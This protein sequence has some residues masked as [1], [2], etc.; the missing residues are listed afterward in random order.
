MNKYIIT[1]NSKNFKLT[2]YEFEK[3]DSEFKFIKWIDEG[4]GLIET[5]LNNTELCRYI[6]TKPVIF[7]RH[8]FRVDGINYLNDFVDAIV[9]KCKEC[10]EVNSSFTVQTRY[11]KGTQVITDSMS[12]E[13]ANILTHVGY[14]VDVTKGENIISILIDGENV[15]W[16][17]GNEKNN[18]SH[19]RGGMPHYSST[20]KYRF[21]SR[22]EYKLLEA[23]ECFEIDIKD[24]KKAADLGAAPGG[25][26]KVLVDKGLECTSI[27]PSYLK[28]EISSNDKVKYYHMLVE[29]YLKLKNED[30]F[31]IVV[32]DMK[33]D[34]AKSISVINQFYDKINDGGIVI[35]T[36]KLPHEYN[37]SSIKKWIDCF[38]GYALIT[39]RQLFHNRSEI[40]VA[41]KKDATNRRTNNDTTRKSTS[42]DKKRKTISKKL[43][44]KLSKKKHMH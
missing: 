18:L 21:V 13:I 10:I 42:K 7:V 29:D 37:Y 44:R 19:W 8:V 17:I 27:D 26:T 20:N 23:L 43:E 34:V 41:L 31:D 32:N 16:G 12:T 1:C 9:L 38:N 15:Y 4:I 33:M 14:K 36:F 35:I 2:T 3:S 6:K 24:M 39:A 11:T 28:P 25:W 30:K 22:A 40:T 5:E